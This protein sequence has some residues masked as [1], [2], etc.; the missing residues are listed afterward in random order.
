MT[1]NDYDNN[2]NKDKHHRRE[3]SAEANNR[4]ANGSGKTFGSQ[5]WPTG[6]LYP[7]AMNLNYELAMLT[8]RLT[9]S[10]MSGLIYVGHRALL[11]PS[12]RR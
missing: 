11:A 8:E 9:I 7:F 6:E 5:I 1:L 4:G 2:N 3:S 10:M 12:A